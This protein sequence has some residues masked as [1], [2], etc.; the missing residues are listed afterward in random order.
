[1]THSLSTRADYQAWLSS[2]KQRVQSARMRAALAANGELIALYYEL[3]AQIVERET[4]A[5]WGSGFIN[6]F[7]NDLRHAFPEVGGF[8]PKNLRYC[9]AFFRFYCDPAIWQQAVAKLADTPWAG[10]V[11]AYWPKRPGGITSRFSANALT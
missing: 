4:Q 2:I 11:L 6:A 3:G 7:S 1:M 10:I 9:R 8:S 5:Q